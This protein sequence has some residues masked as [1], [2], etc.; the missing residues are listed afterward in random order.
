MERK[1]VSDD[2]RANA[3]AAHMVKKHGLPKHAC[4]DGRMF[5][6]LPADHQAFEK[7]LGRQPSEVFRGMSRPLF[8]PLGESASAAV[9]SLYGLT[10]CDLYDTD[11]FRNAVDCCSEAQDWD[12]LVEVLRASAYSRYAAVLGIHAGPVSIEQV[13]DF[14]RIRPSNLIE[15]YR[16]LRG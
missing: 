5:F 10:N 1:H 3:K 12:S 9:I 4:S 2:A 13:R 11:L 6:V 16:S 15:E 8:L 14:Q 7:L